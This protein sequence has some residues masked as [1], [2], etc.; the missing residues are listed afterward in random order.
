MFK[1]GKSFFRN[2][3][4]AKWEKNLLKKCRNFKS[5][6]NCVTLKQKTAKNHEK[7]HVSVWRTKKEERMQHSS[8]YIFGCACIIRS[9]ILRYNALFSMQLAWQI[10]QVLLT[11]C[12]QGRITPLRQ[13]EKQKTCGH[14]S[15]HKG[16]DLLR[17]QRHGQIC[18]NVFF[19]FS[20]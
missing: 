7:K 11:I 8:I 14:V 6:G 4:S 16:Y 12:L 9:M 5:N 20:L 1:W 13:R 17:I 2:R 18:R 3:N 10:C 19:V 15:R